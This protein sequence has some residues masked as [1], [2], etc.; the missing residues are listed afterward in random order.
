[1]MWNLIGRAQRSWRHFTSSKPGDRFQVRYYYR[2]QRGPGRLSRIFN[3]VVGGALVIFSAF[4]GWAPGPGIVTFV[5][6]LAMVGG[7]FLVIA[8]FLDWAEVRLRVLAHL[9]GNVWRSSPIGKVLLVLVALILVAAF[10]YVIY[11]VFFAG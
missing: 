8:R 2:N 10:G 1:M 5:I 9:V 6:G 3:I 7:E 4:F 11:S